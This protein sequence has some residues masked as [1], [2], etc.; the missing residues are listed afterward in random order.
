MAHNTTV[1]LGGNAFLM[2]KV[3][4]NNN[5][6]RVGV[7]WVCYWCWFSSLLSGMSLDLSPNKNIYLHFHD[8]FILSRK[9][10]VLTAPF[11]LFRRPRAEQHRA[12]NYLLPYRK[13]IESI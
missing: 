8:L 5:I 10:S 11:H 9:F 7:N 4:G 2:C 12:C 13:R 6:D 1:Q 3:A